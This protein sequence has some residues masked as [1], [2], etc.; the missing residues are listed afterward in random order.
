MLARAAENRSV[1]FGL[2]SQAPANCRED[3]R[4]ILGTSDP[5]AARGVET[6]LDIVWMMNAVASGYEKGEGGRLEPH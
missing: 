4:V 6:P 1:Y 2:L 3:S 5:R